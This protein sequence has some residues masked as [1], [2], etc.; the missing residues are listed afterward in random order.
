[1]I[2]FTL[3]LCSVATSLLSLFNC[4]FKGYPRQHQCIPQVTSSSA[5]AG[6]LG[7]A[8][9]ASLPIANGSIAR[10]HVSG[11]CLLVFVGAH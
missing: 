6:S 8:A 3:L 5:G 4:L 2:D 11:D 10:A 1:M 7:Q 9:V